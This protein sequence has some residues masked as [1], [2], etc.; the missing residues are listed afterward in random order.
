M[1]VLYSWN[2][3]RGAKWIIKMSKW[4]AFTRVLR[5]GYALVGHGCV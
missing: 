2:K 4:Y 5:E 1:T 3:E